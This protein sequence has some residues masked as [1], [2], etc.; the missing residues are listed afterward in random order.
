MT[1]AASI[2]IPTYNRARYLARVLA[3]LEQ[4]D[5]AA[6][7]FEVVVTDDGSTDDTATVLAGTFSYPLVS[8]TQRNA[9][10]AAARNAAIGRASAELIIFV[11][12]DVIPAPDLVRRH[13]EA[14]SDSPGV[15][16]GRMLMPDGVRQPAWAEWE[17][18]TVNRQYDQMIAGIFVPTPR[19]FYTAN[20]SVRRE[21]LI[22]A[23]LFDV[24]FRR[25][26][27]VELAYRLGDLGL[28]FRF[29]PEAVVTHDTPRSLAG[30]MRMAQQYGL[31]DVVMWRDRGRAQILSNIAEEFHIYRKRA[32]QVA[33][34]IAVGRPPIMLATQ[35]VDRGLIRG[36]DAVRMRKAS[37][38]VCSLTFNLL[39]LDAVCDALGGRV[40]F[41]AAMRRELAMLDLSADAPAT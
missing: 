36:L 38:A 27:D 26:E 37:L 15:V 30:W 34:H 11:D 41:W 7:A 14:Q 24:E 18:R 32:L 2:V 21:D 5:T 16:I 4:Q 22:R 8:L 39:Y 19:Q 28:P 3:S 29:V 31:C 25:A 20:A 17:G 9:G 10:P 33:A 13:I 40:A 12:D 1:L 23:G 6:G 35:I